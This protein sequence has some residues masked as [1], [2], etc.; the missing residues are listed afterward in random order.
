MILRRHK[1]NLFFLHSHPSPPQLGTLISH[2]RRASLAEADTDAEDPSAMDGP[3]TSLTTEEGGS[4]AQLQLLIRQLASHL[5]EIQSRLRPLPAHNASYRGA[6]TLLC[7]SVDGTV[8][9]PTPE[10]TSLPR[11]AQ[12]DV[13]TWRMTRNRRR[14]STL[15]RCTADVKI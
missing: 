15:N 2:R 14:W 9:P 1:K 12:A 4:P 7:V 6:P 8:T 5:Q 13:A 3:A 10:Q 11:H